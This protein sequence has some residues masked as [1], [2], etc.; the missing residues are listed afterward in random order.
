MTRK[1]LYDRVLSFDFSPSL[2]K[3]SAAWPRHVTRIKHP[4]VDQ[5]SWS[6]VGQMMSHCSQSN[7]Y[8]DKWLAKKM[9]E[10]T[11]KSCCSFSYVSLPSQAQL[12]S[13]LRQLMHRD[14]SEFQVHTIR[15]DLNFFL[16]SYLFITCLIVLYFLSCCCW[17]YI[18]YVRWR[19]EFRGIV[20]LTHKW[21][22]GTDY[23]SFIGP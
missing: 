14:I 9:L 17:S 15:L 23:Q 2:C 20:L 5:M 13:H 22:A 3:Q 11:S 6:D 10:I 21:R 19:S 7:L 8:V 1:S 18:I 4:A 12:M 16:F